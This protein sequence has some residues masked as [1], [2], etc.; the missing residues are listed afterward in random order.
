MR[1]SQSELGRIVTEGRCAD[2]VRFPGGGALE[3]RVEVVADGPVA[4]ELA[5]SAVTLRVPR[6]AVERWSDPAE[7]SIAGEQTL[8]DGGCLS[9]LLEKD[10]ACLAPRA[11]EDESDLFA[12]PRAGC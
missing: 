11:G 6:A 8:D 4:A 12:N 2:R 1:V 9:L 3:Y 10:F 7:V 5:G